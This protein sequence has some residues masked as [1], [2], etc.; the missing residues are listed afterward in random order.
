LRRQRPHVCPASTQP[1]AFS[2]AK[3]PGS[4]EPA[5]DEI[6]RLVPNSLHSLDFAREH[7][8]VMRFDGSAAVGQHLFPWWAAHSTSGYPDLFARG[9]VTERRRRP[10]PIFPEGVAS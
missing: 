7:R 3:L 8:G 10:S 1:A 6:A 9:I 4:V 5:G 2:A